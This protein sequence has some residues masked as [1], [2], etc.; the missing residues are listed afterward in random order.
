MRRRFKW[1]ARV[2]LSLPFVLAYPVS[3]VLGRVSTAVRRRRGLLPRLVWGPTPILTIATS[4]RAMRRLGYESVDVVYEPYAIFA[5]FGVNLQAWHRRRLARPFLPYAVFLWALLRFDVFH[6]FYDGGFLRDTPW[7]DLEWRLLRWAGKLG[8]ASAYGADV[9]TESRTRALG[10]YVACTDC[11]KPGTYCV[12]NEELGRARVARALRDAAVCL[13]MGDMLEYTGG[14]RNDLFYWPIDLDDWPEVGAEP[15]GGPVRIVHASNHR[16][17]KG[18]RFLEQAVAELRT[19]GLALELDIVERVTNDEARRRYAAADIVAEQFLI[20]YFGYFA[21]EAMALGKPVLTFVRKPGYLPAGEECPIVSASPTT[22]KA[23]LRRLALD[24]ERRRTLGR[25]GRRFVERV[26]SLEAFGRR[27]DALYRSLWG[28]APG[29][30]PEPLTAAGPQ[31][32]IPPPVAAAER[33]GA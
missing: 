33:R 13:S 11:D 22:L 9:R 25:A 17:F 29:L 6:A 18:T 32:R 7:A 15:H 16:M 24:G 19:E 21:V 20:G 31:G 26:F 27:M 4:C 1:A 5:R 30:A 14:S 3:A 23:E 8:I 12:C 10:E 2:L 28:A